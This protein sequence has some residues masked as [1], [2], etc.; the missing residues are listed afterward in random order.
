MQRKLENV[1]IGSLLMGTMVLFSAWTINLGDQSNGGAWKAPATSAKIVNPL[2]GDEAATAKGK[3]LYKQMCVICH[4]EKG[5]GDGMAGAS[6][7]PR[8]ANFTTAAVQNQKDGEIFWKLTE[9]RA[10]MAS[11]KAILK[12]NQR[13]ELINYIRTLKK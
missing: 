4:G 8:P 13:W 3:K 2:K 10:P 11:Y 7:N 9:G 12:E 5:K 6:L 1:I